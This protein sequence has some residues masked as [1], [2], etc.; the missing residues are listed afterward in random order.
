MRKLFGENPRHR[1]GK[2]G[3]IRFRHSSRTVIELGVTKLVALRQI[4][5]L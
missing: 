5:V 1:S 3:R 4:F 2:I